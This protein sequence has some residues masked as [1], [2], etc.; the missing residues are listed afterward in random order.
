MVANAL[1]LGW[2]TKTNSGL[3][4]KSLEKG[5]CHVVLNLELRKL[6]VLTVLELE[7]Y[8]HEVNSA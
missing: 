1:S 4:F 7:A 3:T 8:V 6:A 2:N 5:V